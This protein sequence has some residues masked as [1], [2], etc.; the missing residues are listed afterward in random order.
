VLVFSVFISLVFLKNRKEIKSL[1][2][3]IQSLE[4]K[5]GAPFLNDIGLNS[6]STHFSIS[7]PNQY[8]INKNDIELDSF[9]IIA[10]ISGKGLFK[11]A[12]IKYSIVGKNCSSKNLTEIF[13]TISGDYYLRLEDL[14]LKAFELY[15]DPHKKNVLQPVI[16]KQGRDSQNKDISIPLNHPG[17]KNGEY[18][19]LVLEYKWPNYFHPKKDY[20]FLDNIYAKSTKKIKLTIKIPQPVK[21]V[22]AYRYQANK[23]EPEFLGTLKEEDKHYYSFE[24]ENPI[25]DAFYILSYEIN[26]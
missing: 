1:K 11:D 3:R 4:K 22:G 13:L 16:A 21:L 19:N 25:K 5:I 23:R 2:E 6:L 26:D 17:K 12:D 24:A 7:N 15:S 10:S 18:F 14:K 20:L 8:L 9:E